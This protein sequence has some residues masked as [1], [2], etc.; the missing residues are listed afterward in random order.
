MPLASCSTTAPVSKQAIN[1][2]KELEDWEVL[3]VAEPA[4]RL[5]HRFGPA[6]VRAQALPVRKPSGVSS[7]LLGG[8]PRRN[9]IL[10]ARDEQGSFVKERAARDSERAASQTNVGVSP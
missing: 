3:V 2:I 9:E 7:T 6:R 5:R 1:N 8:L 4:V 10:Q